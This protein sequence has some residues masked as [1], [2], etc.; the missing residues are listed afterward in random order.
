MVT[1]LHFLNDTCRQYRNKLTAAGD[2][3]FQFLATPCKKVIRTGGPVPHN[4]LQIQHPLCAR[5]FLTE[6]L[7]HMKTAVLNI[8]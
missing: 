7:V 8:Q 6:E 5:L 1:L 3:S 4:L 2:I